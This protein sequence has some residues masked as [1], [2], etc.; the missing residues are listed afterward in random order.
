MADR[1]WVGGS[2]NWNTTAGTKWAATSGG[3]GGET[4]PTASDN[5][6]FDA[7]SGAVT[8]TCTVTNACA[9]L[10]FTSG[11]GD[12]TGTFAGATALNISGGLVV[13]AG[14]TITYTG[15][16]TF[17]GVGSFAINTNGK[18]LSNSLTFNNAGGIWTLGGALTTGSTRVISLFA[19]TLDLSGYTLTAGSFSTSVATTRTLAFGSTGEIILLNNNVSVWSGSNSTGFTVTGNKVVR[20]TYSGSTGQRTFNPSTSLS[21]SNAMKFY[22][23]AG[24][25]AVSMQ[26]R[27]A[28]LDFTG[29]SGS[30]VSNS[31]AVYGSLTLSPTMTITDGNNGTT[32]LGTSGSHTITMNGVL[33]AMPVT[34]NGNGG[35]WSFADALTMGTARLL[36]LTAGT[37]KLKSGTT[38]TVDTITIAGNPTVYLSATTAGS[39]ATLSKSSGTVSASNAVIQDINATGGATWQAFTTNNNVDAG[40]NTG[41]DFSSQLGRYI[42]NMRKNKR[43]L[44]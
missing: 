3:T 8:V 39:Q 23:T 35:T 9:N 37:V 44:P 29:F 38:N 19:G 1:Y 43:I 30:L 28:D 34:F 36:T 22:I 14:M 6:Y 41:W 11:S 27:Y 21:E 25:D 40:N 17:N 15:T 33:C 26:G 7:N 12:F 18:F 20:S 42:Y 32:F 13:S 2:D 24:S 4:V 10:S 5:V 16:M 31:R